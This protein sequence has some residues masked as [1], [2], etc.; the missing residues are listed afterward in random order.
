MDAENG[1]T[2]ANPAAVEPVVAAKAPQVGLLLRQQLGTMQNCPNF[3]AY[4]FV[5]RTS[6]L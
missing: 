6:G 1:T 2:K 3:E 4:F 5:R